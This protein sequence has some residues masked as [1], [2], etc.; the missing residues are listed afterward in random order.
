MAATTACSQGSSVRLASTGCMVAE[1][2]DN[3]WEPVQFV[4]GQSHSLLLRY[5]DGKTFRLWD[6]LFNT[7]RPVKF[8]LQRTSSPHVVFSVLGKHRELVVRQLVMSNGN[9]HCEEAIEIEKSTSEHSGP[10]DSPARTFVDLV[11]LQND[12]VRDVR[13]ASVDY[14]IYETTNEERFSFYKLD[15]DRILTIGPHMIQVHKR[16]Y[17]DQSSL[18]LQLAW[19]VPRENGAPLYII[20]GVKARD[21]RTF[22]EVMYHERNDDCGPKVTVIVELAPHNKQTAADLEGY[23]HHLICTQPKAFSE[24]WKCHSNVLESIKN[25][26]FAP[27]DNTKTGKG[28]LAEVA[29]ARDTDGVKMVLNYL[30]EMADN[31]KNIGF[32][33]PVTTSC[34]ILTREYP[35]DIVALLK[36]KLRKVLCQTFGTL[37]DDWL[38]PHSAF[39]EIAA[40]N[41]SDVLEI[42]FTKAV[43]DFKWRKY[44]GQRFLCLTALQVLNLIFFAIATTPG[45]A[46]PNDPQIRGLFYAVV[47][48]CILFL[49]NELRQMIYSPFTYFWSAYNY[50]DLAASILP[51]IASLSHL[52]YILPSSALQTSFAIFFL[53]IH[54]L[55]ETRIFKPVGIFF[56]IVLNV[57]HGILPFLWF[58]LVIIVAFSHALNLLLDPAI[59]D[60]VR[61]PDIVTNH[62]TPFWISAKCV[63]LALTQDY[64]AFSNIDWLKLGFGYLSR[65]FLA[66]DRDFAFQPADR[67]VE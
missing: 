3:G 29:M 66:Y 56:N 39:T 23:L 33:E 32:M 30:T 52:G 12:Q 13:D 2:K 58:L 7:F 26:R 67:I 16:V 53:W 9:I 50:I 28:F 17:E 46:D 47:V 21:D 24:R 49:F 54:F 41:N 59:P 62:F 42:P 31:T 19:I 64:S 34:G 48:L 51:L 36:E 43:I 55:L 57:V 11:K 8:K 6:F 44:A 37:L 15:D 60:A 4:Y 61:V 20:S 18:E 10:A 63:Y 27:V 1:N 45:S 35:D 14:E 22:L 5:M 65:D 25:K 40:A 38:F